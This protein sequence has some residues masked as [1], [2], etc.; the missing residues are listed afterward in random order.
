MA[1]RIINPRARRAAEH[2]QDVT[3]RRRLEDDLR[4]LAADLSEAG[5]RKNEFIA[6]LAHELR[7]P[8]A[9]LSTASRLAPT[10]EAT[11]G[12]E[13]AAYCS[14]LNAHL[15]RVQTSSASGMRADV[16]RRQTGNFARGTPLHTLDGDVR[17][18]R[19]FRADHAQPQVGPAAC[20]RRDRRSYELEVVEVVGQAEPDER[21]CAR[22]GRV[23]CAVTVDVE[24]CRHDHHARRVRFSRGGQRLVAGDHEIRRRAGSRELP[25]SPAR[26]ARR[27]TR[28][29]RPQHVDG[30]VE[31]ECEPTTH[32][33]QDQGLRW[34]ELDLGGQDHSRT[35]QLRWRSNS[36]RTWRPLGMHMT[37]QLR[38]ARVNRSTTG[39]MR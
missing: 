39:A 4:K 5:R 20:E 36:R 7:N 9:P 29:A 25:A 28:R 38:P 19:E 30:I 22:C 2:S 23:R 26:L 18:V 12:S 24:G 32:S 35:A 34:R 15:P 17:P 37:R 11:H 31:I 6:T 16:R 3:E 13:A 10:S 21:R 27:Q 33:P 14:N 1:A 8:L